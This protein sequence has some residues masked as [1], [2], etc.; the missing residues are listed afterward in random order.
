MTVLQLWML[1]SGALTDLS[2]KHG[3]YES[4]LREHVGRKTVATEEIERDLRRSLPEHPAFQ[5]SAGV[6]SIAADLR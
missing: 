3:Y 6:P 4:L 1:H 5:C 2:G